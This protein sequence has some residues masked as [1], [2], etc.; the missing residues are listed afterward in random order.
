MA[1]SGCAPPMDPSPSPIAAAT[2]KRTPPPARLTVLLVRVP[3]HA[4]IDSHH[5]TA[6][7][8]IEPCQWPEALASIDGVTEMLSQSVPVIDHEKSCLIGTISPWLSG[9]SDST[10]RHC[11]RIGSGIDLQPIRVVRQCGQRKVKPARWPAKSN[12]LGSSSESFIKSP[13]DPPA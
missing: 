3:L 9:N 5:A 1:A 12:H 8:V 10:I 4:Q 7:F 11:S 6:P 13:I 2:W